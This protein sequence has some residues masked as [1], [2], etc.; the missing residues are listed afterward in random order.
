MRGFEKISFKQFK[1][2]ILDDN[3]VYEEYTLPKRNTKYSAGYDFSVV[4]DYIVKPGEIVKIP[5]GIKSYMGEDE[6]LFIIIRSSLGFKYNARL[7]NQVGV[8]DKDYYNN[9]NNEGHIWIALKN[10][11]DQDIVLNKGD[12]FAQGIFIK[13]LTVDDEEEIK[14]TRT[15]GFGSTNKG[16][17]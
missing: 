8:I 9:E 11:G 6:V 1:K 17:C 16:E 13:Y 5:T 3:K 15:G 7:C 4:S 14:S 2:D 12:H 10:E